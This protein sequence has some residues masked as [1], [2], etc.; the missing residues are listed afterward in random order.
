MSDPREPYMV[1]EAHETYAFG[2]TDPRAVW[3][4]EP[5]PWENLGHDLWPFDAECRGYDMTLFGNKPVPIY[6]VHLWEAR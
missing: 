3:G 2:F 5:K 4:R 6:S 1:I